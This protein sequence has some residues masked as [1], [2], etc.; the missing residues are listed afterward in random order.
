MRAA[1]LLLLSRPSSR[2]DRARLKLVAA[3][4]A[5]D[6]ALVLA[7]AR[8]AR[9]RGEI[10]VEESGLGPFVA[11]SGNRNMT[12]IGGLLLCIPVGALFLQS[13]RVGA[14]AGCTA[15]GGAGRGRWRR[16]RPG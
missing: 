8:I 2:A 16:P 3:A 9:L 7:C 12:M 1:T 6:G 5:V 11:N 10:S 15:V 4:V 14:T 13:V